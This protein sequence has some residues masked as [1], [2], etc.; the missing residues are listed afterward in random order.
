MNRGMKSSLSSLLI[1]VFA[2][3]LCGLVPAAAQGQTTLYV[4]GDD[5]G[6]GTPTPAEKLHVVGVADSQIFVENQS[7]TISERILFRLANKGKVRF[8][9]DNTAINAGWTFDNDGAGNFNIS[10]LG[11]GVAELLLTGNG[12]MTIQGVLTELSDVN[13]KE[14]IKPVYGREV[15]D[16]VLELPIARW[17]YKDDAVGARHLGPMAQDFHRLFGL[18]ESEAGLSSLDTTG[19]ALAA[20]QGL[21]DVVNEKN[22][23]IAELE[24]RLTALEKLVRS[25]PVACE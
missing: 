18:G 20:I 19:V 23:V 10:R 15:L 9:L 13:A 2:I 21:H 11:T 8:R 3:L 12:N 7:T 25:G 24:A 5:V 6:I 4:Q 16:R 22:S 14:N 17:S 1:P